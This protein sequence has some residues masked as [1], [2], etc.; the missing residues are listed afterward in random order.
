MLGKMKA[1]GEGATEDEMA[2]W[3]H[4][5]EGMSLSKLQEM[6]KDRE[7]WRAA[8]HG[9]AGLDVSDGTTPV[10][11]CM[12]ILCFVYL[13]IGC[14]YFGAITNNVVM[15]SHKFLY[16]H[17]FSFLLG[18]HLGVEFAGSHGNYMFIH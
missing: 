9:V 2:G 18:I 10:F 7:A 8:V 16:G 15:N 14:F 1:G 12:A 4:R 5:L 13:F 11:H 3:P 17:M 6:V